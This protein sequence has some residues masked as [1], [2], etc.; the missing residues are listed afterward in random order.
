MEGG[1]GLG[2]VVP[3]E[4]RGQ[5]TSGSEF[6]KKGMLKESLEGPEGAVYKGTESKGLGPHWK[7][8]A[9]SSSKEGH[10][11]GEA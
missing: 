11:L 6:L 8:L 4:P 7:Q 1:G 3:W 10:D 2:V 9:G 5:I